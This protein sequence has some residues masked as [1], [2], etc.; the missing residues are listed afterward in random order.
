M[1]NAD[2]QRIEALLDQAELQQ[3][4]NQIDGILKQT[5]TDGDALV[6]KG[7]IMGAGG[8]LKK[9]LEFMD[10][11]LAHRPDDPMAKGYKGVLLF[12]LQ[13]PAPA[14]V[15]LAEATR[16]LEKSPAPFHYTLARCYG[17]LERYTQALEHV[18]IALAQEPN[19]GVYLYAK[20]QLLADL[21]QVDQALVVLGE[22]IKVWPTNPDAWLILARAQLNLNEAADAVKNLQE[23]LKHNPDHPELRESLANAS[24]GAGNVP[25]ATE[26]LEGLCREFP[27]N[28]VLLGNL[29][30]CYVAGQ[31]P[32]DAETIYHRA[33]ELNPQD[34]QLHFQLAGLLEQAPGDGP[35][36]SA[37]EHLERA[38]TLD[39]DYWPAFNDLGRLLTTQAEVQDLNRALNYLQKALDL[40]G[41]DPAP[42][43]NLALCQAHRKENALASQL[44]KAVHSHP[45]APP[46]LKQQAAKLSKAI[47]A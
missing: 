41:H 4:L 32:A 34:A 31:R 33:L 15:L 28:P 39:P 47:R 11:A 25:K 44:C 35:L 16:G 6:I 30:L 29:A 5:P 10:Q 23:G 26:I 12:E 20:A 7:R 17:R 37:I 18:D 9:A 19:N 40:S 2:I 24:L 27:S 3:A 22:S 38:I 13:Q 8:D 42:M 14:E 1:E 43:L 36:R 21:D 46:E 45:L